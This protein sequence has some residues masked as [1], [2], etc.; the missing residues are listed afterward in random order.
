MIELV[1]PSAEKSVV[2][3]A[4]RFSTGKAC[5]KLTSYIWESIMYLDLA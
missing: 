4:S 5:E 2:C 3:A 1:G